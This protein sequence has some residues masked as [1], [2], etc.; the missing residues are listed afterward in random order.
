MSIFA[1]NYFDL[2]A[3]VSRLESMG[4]QFRKGSKTFDLSDL[5]AW[6]AVIVVIALLVWLLVRF[7]DRQD[8]PDRTNSPR[9]LFGE[10]CRVHGL[11]LKDR[12]LLWRVARWQRL[13]HPAKLFLEPE[14]FDAAN[15][16][17]RLRANQ[18][19]LTQLRERL[20]ATEG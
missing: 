17:T 5:V 18:A 12:W 6:I 20:F 4:G 8:G 10:L 16:S 3:S 1:T 13:S 2:I 9:R 14:R 11:T 19:R 15:L 7:K